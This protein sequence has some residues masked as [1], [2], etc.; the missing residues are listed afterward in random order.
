MRNSESLERSEG[1]TALRRKFLLDMAW[2]L[3]SD[4]LCH[5]FG[6]INTSAD[7][8]E[9]EQEESDERMNRLTQDDDVVSLLLSA[10]QDAGQV[11]ALVEDE[12]E[13]QAWLATYSLA[14]INLLDDL[15]VVTIAA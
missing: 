11:L 5:M 2:P 7:V 15:G 14:V 4:L 10:A 6:L 9:A 1:L 8:R 13:R 12:Q 3:S